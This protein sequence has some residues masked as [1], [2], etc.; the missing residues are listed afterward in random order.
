MKSIQLNNL[1]KKLAVCLILAVT[2]Q[3]MFTV[4]FSHQSEK[5]SDSAEELTERDIKE[6]VPFLFLQ[7]DISV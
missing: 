2:I 7:V 1:I 5:N 3:L 4:S 6:Q